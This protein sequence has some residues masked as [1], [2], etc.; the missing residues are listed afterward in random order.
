LVAHL[1]AAAR[2]QRYAI[3]GFTWLWRF[4]SVPHEVSSP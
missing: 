4:R 2:V 3:N 1:G